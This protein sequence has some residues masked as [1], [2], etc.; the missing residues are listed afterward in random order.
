M[1][2]IFDQPFG[3]ELPVLGKF[4]VSVV[5]I[6]PNLPSRDIHRDQY[7][8]RTFQ[9][10]HTMG[11]LWFTVFNVA[12]G[13]FVGHAAFGADSSAVRC[14]TISI[15]TNFRRNGVASALYE[16][17]SCIFEAPVIKS[18][19]LS[20]DAHSFLSN[21]TEILCSNINHLIN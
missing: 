7:D 21:R 14:D 18:N 16:L 6:P 13:K 4:R 20:Q 8:D 12:D 5:G 10:C 9:V 17:A 15:E 3:A 2:V 1:A 19:I 11:T